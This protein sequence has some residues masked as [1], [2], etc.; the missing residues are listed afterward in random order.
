MNINKGGKGQAGALFKGV[1]LTKA[2]LASMP[3][4]EGVIKELMQVKS[5]LNIY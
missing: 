2:Q 4:R 1:K 5:D 3:D